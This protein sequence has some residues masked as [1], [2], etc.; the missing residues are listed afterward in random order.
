MSGQN[1]K[2]QWM[3]CL[4]PLLGFTGRALYRRLRCDAIRALG[5]GMLF[6]CMAVAG[7]IAVI[8]HS[9]EEFETLVGGCAGT[10]CGFNLGP[11]P[12]WTAS[13]GSGSFRPGTNTLYFDLVPDGSVTGYT[14][15]GFL[16]Q[17][18]SE[19]VAEGLLYT[20]LV[21]VGNRKD[22]AQTGTVALLIGG[23]PIVADTVAAPEGGWATHTVMYTG[24]PGDV[25][26]TIGI[27]LSSENQQGN[28]DN[29]R[30]SSSGD[31]ATS[32]IPEPASLVLTAFGLAAVAV[33]RRRRRG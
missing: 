23:V 18:V 7:P 8:N 21:E 26:K 16:E 13:S 19:T 24:L 14:S 27:R 9:F 31:S 28:Y 11:V 15:S 1:R 30:L 3:R 22:F 33:S 6:A 29:V 20:L 5:T 10:N 25:G 17:T 32:P 4:V 12:G 2:I